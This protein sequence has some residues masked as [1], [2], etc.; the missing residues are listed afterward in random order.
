ME[1]TPSLV[2]IKAKCDNLQTALSLTKFLSCLNINGFSLKIDD[3]SSDSIFNSWRISEYM[4]VQRC[5][6]VILK[7]ACRYNNSNPN[8]R[9]LM[10]F[11]VVVWVGLAVLV[12][13]Y[14]VKCCAC[15]KNNATSKNTMVNDTF[16]ARSFPN[17]PSF[18]NSN[19]HLLNSSQ[20]IA[21]IN[22]PNSSYQKYDNETWDN[23]T[24][25]QQV[26]TDA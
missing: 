21:L 18:M 9:I 14:F 11:V 8:E 16:Q 7:L 6:N 12:L 26:T 4:F 17:I 1:F 22:S 23:N 19:N 10:I 24:K 2:K 5:K 20:N 15:R 13:A 25:E 3:F